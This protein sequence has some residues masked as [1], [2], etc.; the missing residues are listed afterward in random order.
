MIEKTAVVEKTTLNIAEVAKLLGLSR[1]TVRKLAVKWHSSDGR[2]GIPN[3]QSDG[4]FI[5]PS[6]AIHEFLRTGRFG[7]VGS[8]IDIDELADAIVRKLLAAQRSV[9]KAQLQALDA[10][11]PTVW[12]VGAIQ[13][14]R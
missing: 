4:R 1:G 9:V 8:V 10:D 13:R 5:F 7:T 12:P 6:A 3:V 14:R 2:D 11:E